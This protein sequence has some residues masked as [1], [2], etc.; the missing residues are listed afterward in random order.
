MSVSGAKF[1]MG[2]S[3]IKLLTQNKMEYKYK[4][5]IIRIVI[6]LYFVYKWGFTYHFLLLK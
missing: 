4:F 1:E 6:I 2:L 3:G 5:L